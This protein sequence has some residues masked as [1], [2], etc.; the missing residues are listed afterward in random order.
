[1]E[2]GSATPLPVEGEDERAVGGEGEEGAEL[3]VEQGVGD[4]ALAE[5]GARHRDAEE[6]CIAKRN[7][8]QQAARGG[9]TPIQLFGE[10]KNQH[11]RE[12]QHAPRHNNG[13]EQLA[14]KDQLGDL[15]QDKRR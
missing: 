6:G 8:Q 14:G 15:E 5:K 4:G 2:A 1:M 10:E 13:R 9:A 7:E 3:I 11:G 12:D